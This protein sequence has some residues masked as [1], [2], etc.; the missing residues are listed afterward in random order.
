MRG[1]AYHYAFDP[2]NLARPLPERPLPLLSEDVTPMSAPLALLVITA[3][4]GAMMLA[5]VWSLRRCGLP[6]VRDWCQANLIAT[7]ALVLF[8]LRG[9]VPDVLTVVVANAALAWALCMFYAGTERFCGTTPPWRWLIVGTVGVAV[10]IAALRYVVDDFSARVALV[11]VFHALLC[12][13]IS[14][15]LIRHRPRDRA[16]SHFLTTATFALGFAL[17]HATR[18]VL[19]A[20]SML[21][22]SLSAPGLNVVFLTLGALVMPAL[23][24]GAVLMIHDSLVRRLEA[25]ANTDALTGVASRKAYEDEAARELARAVRGG[26]SPALVIIDIDRFKSVNDTWGHAAGDAVLRE[27]ARVAAEEIRATDRLARLGGEEFVILLPATGEAEARHVAERIRARAAANPVETLLGS[28]VH[29]TVSGGVATWRAGET[30]AQLSARADAALYRAKLDGRNRT[31]G[32]SELAGGAMGASA[33]AR[34]T[35]PN[36]TTV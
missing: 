29:Y 11:S 14:L 16:A 13:G 23:T 20:M 5:I 22:D 24:M 1:A 15:T 27:F 10:G 17:A 31:V 2:H 9:M 34:T 7:V 18:G 28:T 33:A 25:I 12:A 6:G 36:T 3:A 30:L 35:A 8:A 4:L 26:P 32:Q 19:A 21:G